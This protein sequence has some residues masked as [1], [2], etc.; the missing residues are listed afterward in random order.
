MRFNKYFT[1][2]SREAVGESNFTKSEHDNAR[3]I[4][5]PAPTQHSSVASVECMLGGSI[6]HHREHYNYGTVCHFMCPAGLAIVGQQSLTC[7]GDG[8]SVVSSFDGVAPMCAGIS[9]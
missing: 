7:T 2:I 6:L 8:T 3:A 9:F 5:C 1:R 4:H